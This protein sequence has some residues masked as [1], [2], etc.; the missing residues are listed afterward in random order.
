MLLNLCL[1]WEMNISNFPQ[2]EQ[3]TAALIRTFEEYPDLLNIAGA[4]DG[5]RI[6]IEASSTILLFRQVVDSRAEQFL[7]IDHRI[8][9][10][11][12]RSSI[13]GALSHAN[14]NC[15]FT[16]DWQIFWYFKWIL[17]ISADFQKFIMPPPIHCGVFDLFT[18]F[19]E[20]AEFLRDL[21]KRVAL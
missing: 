2:P 8:N 12:W 7:L 10:K 16:V 5:T 15:S 14:V 13:F 4:I 11:N 1:T 19:M 18:H 21:Q 6:R 20:F 17:L 3:E 9:R